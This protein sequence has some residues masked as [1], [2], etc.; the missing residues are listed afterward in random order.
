MD[1]FKLDVCQ[2]GFEQP[3]G[4]FRLVMQKR[5][6]STHTIHHLFSRRWHK[7]RVAGTRATDPVLGFTKFT[8]CLIGTPSFGKQHSMNFFDQTQGQ[9]KRLPL[10]E[11]KE[12][13]KGRTMGCGEAN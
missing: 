12:I 10:W 1:G 9:W 11:M 5:F 4:G 2:R 8:G 7:N 3:R 13:L 6:Q